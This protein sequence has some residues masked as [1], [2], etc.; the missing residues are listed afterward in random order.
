MSLFHETPADVEFKHN[1]WMISDGKPGVSEDY[2]KYMFGQMELN[3]ILDD[4]FMEGNR[5]KEYQKDLKM[6]ANYYGKDVKEFRKEI[7]KD[8]NV[9]GILKSLWTKKT[10]LPTN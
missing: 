5:K 7:D 9:L 1:Y 10:K 4:C 6:I 2:G 8:R 3:I